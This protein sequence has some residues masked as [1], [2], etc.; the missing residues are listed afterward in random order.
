MIILISV[1][2]LPTSQTI[3]CAMP[4][5]RDITMDDLWRSAGKKQ[6]DLRLVEELQDGLESFVSILPEQTESDGWSR[7]LWPRRPR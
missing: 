6:R 4:E 3:H 5:Y 7:D 1:I 2:I